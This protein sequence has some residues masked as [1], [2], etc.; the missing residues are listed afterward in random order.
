[1]GVGNANPTSIES[2]QLPQRKVW[3]GKCLVIVK[4][5]G[6]PGEI[7]LKASSDKLAGKTVFLRTF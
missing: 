5:T 4:S 3:R 6:K 7:T 2:D 1:V